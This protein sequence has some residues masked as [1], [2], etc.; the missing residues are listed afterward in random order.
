MISSN[1]QLKTG[2]V[3]GQSYKEGQ[4]P[5][6]PFL[7]SLPSSDHPARGRVPAGLRRADSLAPTL[8][9][10]ARPDAAT[11]DCRFMIH[12]T[13]KDREAAPAFSNRLRTPRPAAAP[14]PVALSHDATH[15]QTHSH[16]APTVLSRRKALI[17]CPPCRAQA[18]SCSQTILVAFASERKLYRH[19]HSNLSIN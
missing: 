3:Y 10:R 17:F 15:T 8:R 14:G 12:F 9:T 16:A 11:A 6:P 1:R 7:P 5:P 19:E 18:G 4:K 2:A 13:K